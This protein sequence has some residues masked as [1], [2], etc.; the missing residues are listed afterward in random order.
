MTKIRRRALLRGLAAGLVSVPALTTLYGGTAIAGGSAPRRLVIYW[1][2]NGTVPSRFFPDSAANLT[3]GSILAPLADHAE[4]LTVIR[5]TFGGT[6]DHKTGL[7]FSTTGNTAVIQDDADASVSLDQAIAGAIG[8]QTHRPSLTLAAETKSNRRGYI[9]ANAD[10]SRNSPIKDPVAAFEYMLGPYGGGATG[11]SGDLVARR[12]VLDTVMT[13]IQSLQTR[14][15]PR[16]RIK[17]E[18]H[19]DAIRELEQ[20]L[21]GGLIDCGDGNPVA[22]GTGFDYDQRTRKHCEL[23]AT[24]FAC[25]LTRVVSFMTSPAGHDNTGFGFLGVEHGDLHQGTAHSATAG[26]QDNDASNKMAT[27]HA[28]HA[29]QLAYLID[30]LQQIP[31]GDGTVFDNTAILWTNECSVGNHGH[32]NIP[33]VLAGSLGGYL[34]TG[35]Y[36]PEDLSSSRDY[37]SILATL[38]SGMGHEIE[39]FGA[40]ETSGLASPILA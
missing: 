24:S 13:D 39:T 37:R 17:L 22:P 19:L 35:Q 11:G 16:D 2:P 1:T 8:A 34:R 40:G 30:L 5:T 14:V 33:V 12:S 31:E 18:A 7:P 21:E 28:Y 23:I 32:T 15:S 38:A 36:I 20:G 4:H 3:S 29:Q 10:G 6:G 27:I 26:D 25:D 9:S